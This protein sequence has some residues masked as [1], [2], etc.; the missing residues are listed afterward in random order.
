[1][2]LILETHDELY[3]D[4]CGEKI[5]DMAYYPIGDKDFCNRCME[6]IK[7]APITQYEYDNG[8]RA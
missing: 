8:W 4:Y 7:E 2:V 3:C 6:K 5:V 1:M